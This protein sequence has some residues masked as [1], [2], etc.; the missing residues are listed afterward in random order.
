MP[1]LDGTSHLV[2][3]PVKQWQSIWR[4]RVHTSTCFDVK[5]SLSSKALLLLV[6]YS[7]GF[8]YYIAM[9]QLC[10]SEITLTRSNPH[11]LDVHSPISCTFTCAQFH[12]PFLSVCSHHFLAY[13]S[14]ILSYRL[15]HNCFLH[16]MMEF[17]LSVQSRPDISQPEHITALMLLRY[18]KW[19][20]HFKIRALKLLFTFM[21]LFALCS[22]P[23]V[24]KICPFQ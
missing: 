22:N 10:S 23:A 13:H 24:I 4:L 5:L 16:D 6:L 3:E 21:P 9:F 15:F 7:Y 18:S 14:F 17:Q 2:L 12:V 1:G 8:N 19:C 11:K 20:S